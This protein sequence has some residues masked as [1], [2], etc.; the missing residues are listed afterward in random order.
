ME[1]RCLNGM[2]VMVEP[3][4]CLQ[5]A[6]V[7]VASALGVFP[8]AVRISCRGQILGGEFEALELC[9]AKLEMDIHET[10][11]G[12]VDQK[13]MEL[14]RHLRV[15]E[16]E[17][18]AC[19]KQMA[20]NEKMSAEL[21]QKK[22]EL[23]SYC[24]SPEIWDIQRDLRE[25]NLSLQKEK[26]LVPRLPKLQRL[27][28]MEEELYQETDNLH[29]LRNRLRQKVVQVRTEL[30]AALFNPDHPK[31]SPDEILAEFDDIA[32][33]WQPHRWVYA[34][35]DA[36]SYISWWDFEEV[37][38]EIQHL[39]KLET[40]FGKIE[41]KDSCPRLL[42]REDWSNSKRSW[43]YIR[44]APQ[45]PPDG[46]RCDSC[47]DRPRKCGRQRQRRCQRVISEDVR[48]QLQEYSVYGQ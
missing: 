29:T 16:P 3:L 18:V 47:W 32:G 33:A 1:V 30:Q 27:Q 7:K 2:A 6:K 40:A 36:G 13:R 5:E 44:R 17:L 45:S 8:E 21:E 35:S 39:E 11:F 26:A 12:L 43:K 25:G 4:E 23:F 48:C 42:R 34:F 37:E 38:R 28:K 15:F 46:E 24:L 31:D 22:K 41:L 9:L 19:E 10:L 20:Q 14:A